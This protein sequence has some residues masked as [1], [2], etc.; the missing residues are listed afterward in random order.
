MGVRR[1]TNT[2]TDISTEKA[3]SVLYNIAVKNIINLMK[4]K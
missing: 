2:L 3:V 1:D 4:S